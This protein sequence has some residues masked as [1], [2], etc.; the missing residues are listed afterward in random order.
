MK[1]KLYRHGKLSYKAYLKPAGRGWEVGFVTGS[2]DLFIGNFLHSKEA[3]AWYTQMNKEIQK[4]STKYWITPKSPKAFY[5]KFITNN[6]YKQY[7]K[8]LDKC[9]SKYNRDF[10]R[11]FNKDVKK[12]NQLKKHWKPIERTH[13]RRRVA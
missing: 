2:K 5:Q 1:T 10:T 4:F 8:Y 11:D 9:F 7:Y 6:L 12:Y 13:L 3:N